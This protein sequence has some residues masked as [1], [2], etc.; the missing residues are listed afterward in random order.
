MFK[1]KNLAV[2]AAVL[3]L[4]TGGVFY[5]LSV[6]QHSTEEE[7][8]IAHLESFATALKQ[9]PVKANAEKPEGMK[10]YAPPI[11]AN[12][13][14]VE[15]IFYYD[16]KD[17]CVFLQVKFS[18]SWLET[19]KPDTLKVSEPMVSNECPIDQRGN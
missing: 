6:Q 11:S 7:K 8:A 2:V 9:N 15:G 16:L 12:A 13:Q 14:N 4:V 17:S 1:A 19:G 18:K 5:F 10:S 3:L